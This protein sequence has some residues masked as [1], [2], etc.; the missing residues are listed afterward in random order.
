MRTERLVPSGN[1]GTGDRPLPTARPARRRLVLAAVAAGLIAIPSLSAG[2]AGADPATTIEEKREQ[3]R[4]ISDRL[5]ELDI[6]LS[7]LDE[8]ANEAQLVLADN[9]AKIADAEIRVSTTRAELE[10]SEGEMRSYAVDAYVGG[11]SG[12][13]ASVLMS[14]STNEASQKRGYLTAASDSKAKLV[15]ELADAEADLH[16]ELAELESARDEAAATTAEL[17]AARADAEAAVEE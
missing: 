5:D 7:E 10:A 14:A 3:A 12:E 15:A 1:P 2:F 11:N 13:S 8:Q 6:E 9:E 16:D 4:E 17:D